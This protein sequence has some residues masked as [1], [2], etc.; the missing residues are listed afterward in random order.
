[1]RTRITGLALTLV[2]AAATHVGYAAGDSNADTTAAFARLKTLVGEWKTDDGKESLTYEL[3]AGGTALLER[4]SGA[5]RPTMLT[6]YHRDG[7]RLVLTHYC[8]A[9]NQ[10]RMQAKPFDAGANEIAFDFLDA[11]NLSSPA[12]GHMHGTSIRFVDANHIDTVWEF[13]ENGKATMTERARYARV[14]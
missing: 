5:G 1:M 2:I 6:L 4:E 12:A 11:T 14:H 9:G 7:N 3:V 13:H 10:P 8:M